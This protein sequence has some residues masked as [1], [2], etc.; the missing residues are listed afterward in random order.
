MKKSARTVFMLICLL[1][2]TATVYSQQSIHEAAEQGNLAAVERYLQ[3]GIAVDARDNGGDTPLILAASQGNLDVVKVL[4]DKGAD[5]NAR[6]NGGWTALLVAA[7]H[8]EQDVVEF[9]KQHGAKGLWS[10]AIWILLNS[11]WKRL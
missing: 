5:V 9:L 10:R 4:V 6:D 2:A 7:V 8:E 11:W 3:N 1:M